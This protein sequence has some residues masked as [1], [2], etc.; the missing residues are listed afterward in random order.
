MISIDDNNEVA[1]WDV[2]EL[3]AEPVRVQ[4]PSEGGG[5][6]GRGKISTLLYAPTFLSSELDN[7][8][9]V[10]IAMSDGTLHVF[11]WTTYNFSPVLIRYSQMFHHPR[12]DIISDVK[13]HP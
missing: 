10:Y 13:C 12:G 8:N 3:D 6:G 1:V 4:V 9:N 7:H 11:D 2:R 5:G